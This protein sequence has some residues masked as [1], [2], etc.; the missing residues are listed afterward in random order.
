M[1]THD[2]GPP[3]SVDARL[4]ALVADDGLSERDVDELRLL[5]ELG[6]TLDHHDLQPSSPSA[7]LLDEVLHRAHADWDVVDDEPPSARRPPASAERDQAPPSTAPDEVVR[8]PTPPRRRWAA[9]TAAGVAAAVAL[10]VV[11]PTGSDP[12]EA[13]VPLDALAEDAEGRALL[14]GDTVLLDVDLPPLHDGAFYEVWLLDQDAETLV[15]LGALRSG[16]TL[17]LPP[18]AD[19]RATPLLDVSV[20]EADGD[21]SHSGRSV[22]RGELEA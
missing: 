6:S 9:L 8:A 17:A 5:V 15:S 7:A 14:D 2:D 18:D 10:V 11:L 19:L 12:L 4:R 16:G 21:P 13:A 20:E 22:L 1:T 3:T